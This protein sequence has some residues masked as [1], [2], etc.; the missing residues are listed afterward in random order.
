MHKKGQTATEYLVITAVVIIIAVIVIS[1]LGG[2]PS[3]GGGVSEQAAR[4]ELA[5]M[6]IGVT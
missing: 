5:S 2:I 6:D 1:S 3:I 4:A